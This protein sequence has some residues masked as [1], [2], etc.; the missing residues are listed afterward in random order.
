MFADYKTRLLIIVVSLF[1]LNG[2]VG[3]EKT[4][5]DVWEVLIGALP[6][7]IYLKNASE[8]FIFYILMQTHEPLF[9]YDDLEN[10]TLKSR[11]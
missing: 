1:L 3:R 6:T 7:Q 10:Y 8:T 11:V 9:R 5:A 4:S 2:C